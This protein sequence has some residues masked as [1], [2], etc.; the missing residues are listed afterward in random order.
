M[1]FLNDWLTVFFIGLLAVVSPGSDF[2]LTLRN[3]L[4]Y[5][6]QAGIYTAIA[7]RA[8][9]LVHTTYS[10]VGIGAIISRSILLFNVLKWLGAVYLFYIGIKS[11][12]A[13][14]QSY[15]V[16]SQKQTK[17]ISRCLAF[18]I[19]LLA[20]LLNPKATLFYLVFTQIIH[21]ATPLAAQVVIALSIE[22][23]RTLYRV[24]NELTT[25]YVST[26]NL[27]RIDERT[28]SLVVL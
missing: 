7:V 19:G 14:K 22:Q 8:G 17:D 9:N 23:C 28:R 18:R 16:S 3:S 10:I 26:I 24:C 25:A 5:S 11:L 27:V 4:V 12:R 21:P 20:N 2:A 13:K 1:S 15:Q 6:R